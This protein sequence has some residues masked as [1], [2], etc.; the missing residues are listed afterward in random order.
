MY[1]AFFLRF[2]GLDGEESTTS[3][4]FAGSLRV[5][6][7]RLLGEGIVDVCNLADRATLSR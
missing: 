6:W 1:L 7:G 3:F 4:L 2:A 5:R